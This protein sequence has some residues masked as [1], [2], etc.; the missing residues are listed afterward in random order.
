M[1]SARLLELAKQLSQADSEHGVQSGLNGLNSAINQLVSQP[2][3]PQFQQ[4]YAQSLMDLARAE[5]KMRATFDPSIL[6]QIK[7]LKGEQ[8]FLTDIAQK[9]EEWNAQN[10][11]SPAVVQQNISRIL[12]ERQ[13]YLN[14]LGQISKDLQTVGFHENQLKPGDAEVGFLLPRQLFHNHLD[15]LTKELGVINKIIRIFSEIAT[16]G[17]EPVIVR[18]IST[19][20]PLFFFCLQAGTVL[21]IGRAFNWALDV[22]KKIEEIRKVRAEIEKLNISNASEVTNAL[23]KNIDNEIKR[24]RELEVN[25]RIEGLEE[26]V[27]R[28]QEQRAGLEWALDSI[29]ARV[30]RGMRVEIKFLPPEKLDTKDEDSEQKRD[31]TYSEIQAIIPKLVFPSIATNP[32]LSLPPPEPPSSKATVTDK[33]KLSK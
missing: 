33:N 11:L 30:E 12:T 22:W 13:E 5:A 27:G 10:A 32:V 29:L 14:V 25:S 7:E 8:F 3:D 9:V 23:D 1:N 19:S 18:Q 4:M 28:K 17:P 26:A 6:P 21:A 15:E 2:T 31:S 24:S 16:G 20:D